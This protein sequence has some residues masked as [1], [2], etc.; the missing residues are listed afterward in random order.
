MAE[1]RIKKGT[2]NFKCDRTDLMDVAETAD[3]MS[4]SFKG[5]LMLY[6]T[7]NFMPPAFK[8]QVAGSVNRFDKGTVTI[9]FDN[10]KRPVLVE[11]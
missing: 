4:F 5:G 9:D 10:V 1:V 7:D 3:G 2:V 6:I 11:M 8:Q